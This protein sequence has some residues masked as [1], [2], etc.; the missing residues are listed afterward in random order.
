MPSDYKLAGTM[1]ICSP[2]SKLEMRLPY[3]LPPGLSHLK[4]DDEVNFEQE[5]LRDDTDQST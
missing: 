5:N 2:F 4:W 3:R 1:I